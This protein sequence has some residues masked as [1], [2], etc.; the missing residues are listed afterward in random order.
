[1]N[2]RDRFLIALKRG[3]PDRVPLWELIINDPVLSEV[4]DGSYSRLVDK[5]DIDGVTG[6]ET[7]IFDEVSSGLYRDEWGILWK[8]NK[9]GILYPVRGPI[10]KAYQIR[11]Y[12]PPDPDAEHRHSNFETLVDEFKGE[13]ALVF[14]T[15][16]VFEFSHYLVGGLSKLFKLYYREPELVHELASKI[17][18]YKSRVA[19][20][21]IKCGADVIVSGD[22]YAGVT[23]PLMS[24]RH[25]REFILPYL[26]K[27]VS[28]VKSKGKLFI[29]HTDGYIWPI[30]KDLVETGIDGLHPIEPAA[31]MD[32]LEVK[33]AYGDSI[34]VIGNVDCTYVLTLANL[35]LVEEVVKET[36]AKVAPGGGYILSS[37]NSIHPGVKAENFLTMIKTAKEYGVYPISNELIREYSRKDTYGLIFRE[38]LARIRQIY[39]S[40]AF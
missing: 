36:I 21:A 14:L 10:K 2:N 1:M 32:I 12:E 26:K 25:F 17:I 23:G 30:L 31:G 27:L 40:K 6:F 4:A 18:E 35:D 39:Y 11:D 15:H 5:L 37:S 22:D 3:V 28:L 29:K 38:R 20:R 16:D 34:C 7:Q 13:R 19:E 33:K 9:D 8:A 24:P